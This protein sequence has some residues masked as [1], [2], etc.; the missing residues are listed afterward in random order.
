MVFNEVLVLSPTDYHE[1]PLGRLDPDWAP[2]LD[3]CHTYNEASGVEVL[4]IRGAPPADCPRIT[5]LPSPLQPDPGL[6]APLL[7][8]AHRPAVAG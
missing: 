8:A 5:V 1:R 7:D 2:G 6:H 4:D 3:G